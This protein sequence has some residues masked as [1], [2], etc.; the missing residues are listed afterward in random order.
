MDYTVSN[1]RI[2]TG[3]A[4]LDEMLG[5]NG[6]YRGSP[7]LLTGTGI[8]LDPYVRRNLLMF[9]TS[10]PSTFGLE[11]HL[12]RVHKLVE[13]FDPQLVILDPVSSLQSA[14]TVQDSNQM[15]VRLIDFLGKRNTTSFFVSLTAGGTSFE[16]T[17]EGMSSLVDP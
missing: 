11:M 12:V 10:R 6:L 13:Q 5:G 2:S 17:D 1:Q 15:L 9:H 3:V 4:E 8:D 7:V 16:H 14:G